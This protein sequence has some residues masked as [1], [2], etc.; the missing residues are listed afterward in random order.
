ML[1]PSASWS[2]MKSIDQTWL[3]AD[4]AASGS[5]IGA[6]YKIEDAIRGKPPDERR[7]YREAHARPLLSQLHAWLVAQLI[8]P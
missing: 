1:R 2:C 8:G 6:L 3:T 7:A 4:G 5:G